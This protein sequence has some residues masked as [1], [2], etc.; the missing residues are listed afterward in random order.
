MKIAISA[1]WY[2]LDN[3]QRELRSCDLVITTMVDKIDAIEASINRWETKVIG[4]KYAGGAIHKEALWIR[5]LAHELFPERTREKIEWVTY[6]DLR[7]IS[8]GEKYEE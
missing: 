1:S 3:V 4:V 6:G 5:A 7:R 8:E 2:N